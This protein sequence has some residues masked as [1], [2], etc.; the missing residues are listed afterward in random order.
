MDTYP[1]TV[2]LDQNGVIVYSDVVPLEYEELKEIIDSI[3]S[4]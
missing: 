2:V 4:V 3:P 1:M